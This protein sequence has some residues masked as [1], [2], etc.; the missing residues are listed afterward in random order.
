MSKSTANAFQIISR[1]VT[2]P[3]PPIDPVKYP[4]VLKE[5]K[6]FDAKL[7]ADDSSDRQ[8]VI[9]C[10][11]H[12][13][14]Q[15][16]KKRLKDHKVPLQDVDVY[17]PIFDVS[18]AGRKWEHTVCNMLRMMIPDN[19]TYEKDVPGTPTCEKKT[20]ELD[21]V[22]PISWIWTHRSY[23]ETDCAR[24]NIIYGWYN[25]LPIPYA[26]N[27]RK[28]NYTPEMLDIKTNIENK[29]SKPKKAENKI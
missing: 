10:N 22:I 9:C 12:S 16:Y 15:S 2:N 4:K 26:M 27:R 24:I 14:L 5:Y 18:F 8:K 20:M 29:N 17:A 28:T 19:A 13:R 11:I 3:T 21:H 25:L 6:E 23:F 7:H 1:D